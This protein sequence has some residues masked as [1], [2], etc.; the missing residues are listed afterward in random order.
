MGGCHFSGH[1]ESWFLPPLPSIGR[2]N[3]IS[4]L[5]LSGYL[6]HHWR[7]NVHL[8]PGHEPK[9]PE[10]I[11]PSSANARVLDAAS[12]SLQQGRCQLRPV[13]QVLHLFRTSDQSGLTLCLIL[14]FPRTQL[15]PPP[16]TT[17]LRVSGRPPRSR[18][19][20]GRYFRGM[21][22]VAPIR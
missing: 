16:P 19:Q 17:G 11:E 20:L 12:T 15:S 18:A 1:C 2:G 22:I 3:Y 5:N 4:G 7:I 13:W 14:A 10:N 6:V 9:P 21:R 8:R